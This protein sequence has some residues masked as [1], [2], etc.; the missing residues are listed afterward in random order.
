MQEYYKLEERDRCIESIYQDGMFTGK[1]SDE[2]A[3]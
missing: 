1:R 2:K 3:G